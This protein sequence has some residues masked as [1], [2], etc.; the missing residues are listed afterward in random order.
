M[1]KPCPVLGERVH[2]F[3][4]GADPSAFPLEA[5][6]R[7]VCAQSLSDCKVPE[8]YSFCPQPLPQNLNGKVLKRELRDR[9]A[10]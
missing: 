10:S 8:S 6:L 5:E 4:V 9:L 2:A 3:V 1:A 7:H